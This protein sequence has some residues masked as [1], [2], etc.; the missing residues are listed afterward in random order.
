M[1]LRKIGLWHDWKYVHLFKK[2]TIP[3]LPIQY[4]SFVMQYR[5]HVGYSMGDM[6]KVVEQVG[7]D[8]EYDFKKCGKM[9][10]I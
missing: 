9:L 2:I 4:Y 10:A 1:K 5:L 8:V 7:L 6:S 3:L